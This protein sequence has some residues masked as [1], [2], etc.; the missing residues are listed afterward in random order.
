MRR[1]LVLSCYAWLLAFTSSLVL[2]QTVHHHGR[3]R[4]PLN[5]GVPNANNATAFSEQRC[6]SDHFQLFCALPYDGR[7]H[8]LDSSCGHCGDALESGLTG[9]KLTAELSQNFQKDNLCTATDSP[10][11]ITPQ[12]L[13]KLQDEVNAIPGFDYGNSHAGGFGPPLD[14]APLKNMARVNGKNLQEGMLVRYVGFMVEE[15]YSPRSSSDSGE[16][17]NC[18]S[19]DHPNVDIHIALGDRSERLSKRADAAEKQRVLCPT[20]TA[21]MVPH[22]R[23]DDWE[24]DQL[25]S[26][27]DRQVRVTGQLFFDGSHRACDDPRRATS[28]PKRISSWEIHPVYAFEICKSTSGTCDVSRD[29][30]WEPVTEA[31]AAQGD[32]EEP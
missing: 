25:D 2:A 18:G 14:R 22:F 5:P 20:I 3:R 32:H 6:N 19:T 11:V 13:R 23:P 12:D 17:V 21:E 1:I 31:L 29:A 9:A 24:V 15:H 28:D 27:S 16:S 30:D 26:V 4:H 8:E 10:T 7:P